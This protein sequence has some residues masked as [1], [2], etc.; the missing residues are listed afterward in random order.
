MSMNHSNKWKASDEGGL[1]W[2]SDPAQAYV[3][4]RVKSVRKGFIKAGASD[5]REFDIDLELPLKPPSRT[6]KEPPRRVL[7]RLVLREPNGVENMDNLEVLHEASILENIERRF[8]MDLIYTNT[9][10]ILIAMNPFKWLPIYGEDVISRFHGKPYGSMPPHVFQEAEDAFNQLQLHRKN[11][12]IVICGES[13]AGKTESTKLM[14]HYLA[15][16]SKKASDRHQKHKKLQ[17]QKD[18]QQHH[19]Q[20]SSSSSSHGPTIAERMVDT[21]PLLEAY[22]NAKTLRNDN[23]SRFGKFTRFDFGVNSPVITGGFVENFLLEKVRVCE[24]GAGERNYH[25]FYQLLAAAKRGSP[26]VADAGTFL[27]DKPSAR[28]YT[29][30]CATIENVDDGE[31]FDATVNAMKALFGGQSGG[32]SGGQQSDNNKDMAKNIF[33]VTAAVFRLGDVDFE[34]FKHPDHHDAARVANVDVLRDAAS[35]L[36]LRKATNDLAEALC[37]RVRDVGGERVV[38][39]NEPVHAASLRDALAKAIYSRLFDWIVHRANMAFDRSAGSK[40]QFIGVLDIYGFEIMTSNGFEQVFI[41]TTNEQLQKVFND[42]IFESEAEEYARE[43]I[44][45]DKTS[46]PDNT[47]CIDLLT[48]KPAGILRMLDAECVRGNAA[49]DG[50]KFAAKLN[51]EHGR[52]PYFEVCGPASVWRRFNGDRTR[53]EDFLVHHFAGPV[54]YTVSQF[55]D[56]NRDALFGHVYDLL[57]ADSTDPIVTDIFPPTNDG[58][59]PNGQNDVDHTT[60][61]RAS[62]GGSGTTKGASKGGGGVASAAAASKQTVANKY[63]GQLSALVSVLRESSTRFVRCIKTNHDKL[64]AKLDKPSCL[65]QLICSGVMAALEVR[66]AGYPTRLPYREFIREFRAFT[67]KGQR[68][69]DDRDLAD[70]MMQHPHV[71]ERIGAKKYKLAYRLGVSKIFMQAEIL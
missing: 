3:E 26:L 54:V 23:S 22:G 15:T 60:T 36:G 2:V 31:E 61:T 49:S 9:G 63:L 10:P 50:A 40:T 24:Q 7:P 16:V 42:I 45:W 44:D 8:R 1:C 43:Q 69:Y 41:N 21:N 5:G 25:V 27:K 19:Q 64:P 18:S 48:K 66:R 62:G 6:Q 17:Q 47:P 68:K 37:V 56:K 20:S 67:P 30:G 59:Q 39:R 34:S 51:K 28:R 71:V 55:I 14:L 46:F 35:L 12:A 70:Q 13:G 53:D 38:S 65:H 29:A 11:Q 57:A 4:A 52:H 33:R 58:G 32:Q